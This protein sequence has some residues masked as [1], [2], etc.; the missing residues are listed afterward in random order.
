MIQIRHITKRY[1]DHFAVKDISF[2]IERGKIY[3]LLGPNG[4]GKSTT[5]NIMTGCLSAT[6][7]TVT[8]DGK[9]VFREPLE[10]KRRIGYL[11]EIPPLYAE[12]TPEEYL[13]FVSEAKG[14]PYEDGARQVK[15]VLALTGTDVVSDRLI[16]NL[17]KGYKQRVGIAQA[18]LG[19]PEVIILDEPTVGLDP[20]QMIEIRSLIKE[21]G[22]TK[23]VIVSS[24]I[25]SEIS[26]VCD[27]VMII[28]HGRLVA[29]D[30][31][32]ALE[33]SVSAEHKLFLTVRGT[34]QSALA[35]LNAIDAVTDVTEET[36]S[37]TDTCRF[38]MRFDKNNDPRETIFYMFA[39]NK[40]PI[41]DMTTDQVTLED[42]FLQLTSEALPE[43]EAVA[44]ENNE[45]SDYIPQFSTTARKEDNE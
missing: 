22:K 35:L 27:H 8:V 31:I 5:M 45:G 25:L 33:E 15:E 23:T 39:E 12:M 43:E 34:A 40:L 16:R 30:S 36:T 3:G 14:V 7:G 2:D 4:A 6:E 44:D 10:A 13:I 17:S 11:P 18:L 21:L 19:N 24:H 38:S 9:D 42:I 29:N 37:K 1:G 32:A 20:K 26:A 28:S 41:L